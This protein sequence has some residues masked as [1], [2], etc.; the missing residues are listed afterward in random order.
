VIDVADDH[1]G[2]LFAFDEDGF[3]GGVHG[4]RRRLVYHM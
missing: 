3:C 4:G 2:H 1:H